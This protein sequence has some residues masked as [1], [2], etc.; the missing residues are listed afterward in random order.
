VSRAVSRHRLLAVGVGLA[1]VFVT[2]TP[3]MA[4]V[5][6]A[7]WT[8]PTTNAD[9]SALTDLASFKVYYGTSSAPCPGATFVSVP[10]PTSAPGASQTAS[11]T[12]S[13][14]TSGATYFA[15]VTAVNSSGAEGACSSVACSRDETNRTA[16]AVQ[17]WASSPAIAPICMGRREPGASCK[18]PHSAQ[19]MTDVMVRAQREP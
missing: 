11:T 1:T 13:G 9:G 16:S 12:L 7:S 4:G 6:N 17:S 10:A 2:A 5:L 14:L 3:I 19:H 18:A 15:A 8:M